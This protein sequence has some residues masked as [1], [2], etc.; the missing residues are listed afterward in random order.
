MNLPYFHGK[1]NFQAILFLALFSLSTSVFSQVKIKFDNPKRAY[2]V[3]ENISLRIGSSGGGTGTYELT[4]DPTNPNSTFKKG[5]FEA[6]GGQD[7]VI[8]FTVNSPGIVFVRVNQNG[9]DMKSIAVEPFNIK[10]LEAEPADFDAFWQ[11]Q[12]G[13]L[14]AVPMNPQLSEIQTLPNGSKVYIISLDQIDNRKVWGYLCVPS[15]G[16]KFPAVLSLPPFGNLN[17]LF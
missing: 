15:G 3:G 6:N 4:Y 13:K 14:A 7:G 10:P 16:G 11:T 17:N 1:H 8:N 5:T 9:S 12:K 2:V